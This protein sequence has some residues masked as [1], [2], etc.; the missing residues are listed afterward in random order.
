MGEQTGTKDGSA[1]KAPD[2][3]LIKKEESDC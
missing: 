3:W 2:E 1:G